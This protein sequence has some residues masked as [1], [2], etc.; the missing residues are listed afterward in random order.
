[1]I[2]S[3]PPALLLSFLTLSSALPLSLTGLYGSFQHVFDSVSHKLDLSL[4]SSAGAGIVSLIPKQEYESW[5][6][7]ETDVAFESIIQ[8]IGSYGSVKGVMAGTVVAS[9]SKQNPDYFYQVRYY[10]SLGVNSP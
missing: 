1:M 2:P 8:N 6:N 3:K 10:L 7:A 9:P 4:H 5:I